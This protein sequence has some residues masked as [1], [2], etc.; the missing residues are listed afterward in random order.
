MFTMGNFYCSLWKLKRNKLRKQRHVNQR[1]K[2]LSHCSEQGTVQKGMRSVTNL[3]ERGGHPVMAI[4]A[5]PWH[6]PAYGP[7]GASIP[8]SPGNFID[9]LPSAKEVSSRFIMLMVRRLFLQEAFTLYQNAIKHFLTCPNS[10]RPSPPRCL[11][12]L[13]SRCFLTCSAH[14]LTVRVFTHRWN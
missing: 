12:R 9:T 4:P 13:Y 6:R 2:H 5:L 3:Q 1:E 14:Q 11:P 7:W 8:S 10:C